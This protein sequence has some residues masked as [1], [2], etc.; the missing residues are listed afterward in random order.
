M[1]KKYKKAFSMV[2]AVFTIVIMSSLTAMIMNTTSKTVKST[3]LQYQKEQAALLARSYTELALLYVSGY[4]RT[5]GNCLQTINAQYGAN[6]EY[7][8]QV[9]IQYIGGAVTNLTGCISTTIIPQTTG[10]N[11]DQTLSI[12]VDVYVRYKDYDD[13]SAL[14]ANGDRNIT[15]HKRTLQRI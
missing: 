13:P 7:N 15:F 10:K 5:G 8:I 4:D 2:T 1:I 6:N 11:F 14:P 12:V 9:E 3:T